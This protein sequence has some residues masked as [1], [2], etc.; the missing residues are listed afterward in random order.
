MVEGGYG[1]S[2][3]VGEDEVYEGFLEGLEFWIED[4]E[5]N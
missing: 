3:C 5:M 2:G 4:I 1:S